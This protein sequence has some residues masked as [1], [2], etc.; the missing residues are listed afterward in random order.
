MNRAIASTLAAY[1][2]LTYTNWDVKLPRAIFAIN[3]AVH[4]T[5]HKS[6]FE[7]VYGRLPLT[8]DELCFPWTPRD[9]EREEY[10]KR[11]VTKWRKVAYS[12]IRA[13]QNKSKKL[14]DRYRRPDPVFKLGD[15]VLVARKRATVGKTK[16]FINRSKGPY[17]VVKRVSR[18]CYTVEDLPPN[19]LARIHRRFNVHVSLMRRYNSR[20]EVDW[21]PEDESEWSDEEREVVEDQESQF[22]EEELVA[23][24]E[25]ELSD[26]FEPPLGQYDASF[27]NGSPSDE[28]SDPLPELNPI[29]EAAANYD[30]EREEYDD[31][32]SSE[33]EDG[34]KA[35]LLWDQAKKDLGVS[36]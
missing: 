28:Q 2:D 14:A 1:V 17:Q 32:N 5:T 4:S 35:W 3:S 12:L 9:P 34:E 20:R 15:L 16:K 31:S 29:T 19:R 23:E 7:L 30:T 22:S 18:L 8:P 26:R 10:F 24:Q 11:K 25:E 36:R 6:P 27:E 33:E 21:K 13:Q